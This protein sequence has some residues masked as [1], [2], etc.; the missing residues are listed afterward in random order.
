MKIND[1]VELIKSQILSKIATRGRV[2]VAIDGRCGSGKT[3]LA[4]A[5]AERIKAPVVHADDFFL[6]P[7]Q[8]TAARLA[9]PGGN[10][11]RER[12]LEEV[13]INLHAGNDAIYRPY[14]CRDGTFGAPITVG[15]C[16][17]VIVEGSY[18]HHPDLACYYDLRVFVDVP[19]DVQLARLSLREPAGKLDAF[20]SRWIPLE[21]KYI[22]AL[23]VKDKADM[24]INLD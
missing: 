13:I 2:L 12:L 7:C 20:V 16:E 14:V 3:T 5:L 17:A 18:S 24:V 21:E 10:L 11:D 1:A 23:S 22:S 8:R 19:A 6:R 4:T 15:A 9:E